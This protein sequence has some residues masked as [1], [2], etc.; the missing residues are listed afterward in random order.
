M[1]GVT[2]GR[3]I[4][5]WADLMALVAVLGDKEKTEDLILA[6]DAGKR[7]LDQQA[8]AFEAH[9]ATQN[10]AWAAK[11]AELERREQAVAAREGD[12]K[13]LSRR[14]TQ[15]EERVAAWD[16]D[17]AQRAQRLD[18]DIIKH[19]TAVRAL[20]AERAEFE[21]TIAAGRAEIERLTLLAQQTCRD[22]DTI[23]DA[24][25]KAREEAQ[26]YL[27][28]QAEIASRARAALGGLGQAA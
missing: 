8:E 23:R 13:S 27:N 9:K 14:E 12:L 6:I 7:Q 17:T 2:P 26:Q 19:G 10:A 28:E 20:A 15:F 1:I 24:A 4:A 3:P 11:A 22:A 18:A 5:G 21:A 16:R 25:V